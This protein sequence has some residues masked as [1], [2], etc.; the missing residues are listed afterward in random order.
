LANIPAATG[1]AGSGACS[2]PAYAFFAMEGGGGESLWGRYEP[3]AM[4][5]ETAGGAPPDIRYTAADPAL[6]KVYATTVSHNWLA[7]YSG[8]AWSQH[9]LGYALGRPAVNPASHLVYVPNLGLP[10]VHVFDGVS[11]QIL[12]DITV[13]GTPLD[14]A[15]DPDGN[16]LYVAT[17]EEILALDLRGNFLYAIPA[18]LADRLLADPCNGDLYAAVDHSIRVFDGRDGTLK[19][20]LPIDALYFDIGTGTNQL[21]AWTGGQRVAAW[22]LCSGELQWED[23]RG[24]PDYSGLGVT[25]DPVNHLAYFANHLSA[26]V[27]VYSMANGDKIDVL[28]AQGLTSDVA[29]MSCGGGCRLCCDPCAG[30]ANPCAVTGNAYALQNASISVI[31]PNTHEETESIPYISGGASNAFAVN[32]F[33][34]LFYVAASD[35]LYLLSQDGYKIVTL[36]SGTDFT[37]TVFNATAGKLYASSAAGTLYIWLPNDYTVEAFTLS[38]A[39]MQLAVDPAANKVFASAPGEGIFVIDGATDGVATTIPQLFAD[40]MAVDPS[41]HMLYTVE[42]NGLVRVYDTQSYGEINSYSLPG[43]AP[44]GIAVNPNTNR[45]YANYGTRIDVIDAGNGNIADDIEA[46]NISAVAVDPVSNQ[47]YYYTGGAETIVLNGNNNSALGLIPMAGVIGYAFNTREACPMEC[48]GIFVAG[49][50]YTQV[51]NI[52]PG[53]IPFDVTEI[54]LGGNVTTPDGRFFTVNTAGVYEINVR[55]P[56]HSIQSPNNG[57]FILYYE[58]NVN[59][60]SIYS[61][62]WDNVGG[63]NWRALV[64]E[65]VQLFRQLNAGDVISVEITS[66]YSGNAA[67]DYFDQQ[68]IAIQKIC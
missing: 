24:I 11:N 3:N 2:E 60:A 52:A 39:P 49:G 15:V 5:T 55:L 46:A 13:S 14:A 48:P 29:V 58:V 17:N 16:R 47:V 19:R 56:V 12:P 65:Y 51:D 44:L 66:Y 37:D 68:S 25:V 4:V 7:V 20:T 43:G 64:T 40:H 67:L 18:A 28:Y 41:R 38:G 6:G 21:V 8:G 31:D 54:D 45:L 1:P 35:G 26:T 32:P 63:Q 36:E 61:A 30:A 9:S 53:T 34:G 10:L 50:Q 33:N 27:D 22:D 62:F 23:Y 42:S 57:D 59:D